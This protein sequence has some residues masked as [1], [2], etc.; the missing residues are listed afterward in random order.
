MK[1]G[2]KL[3][4]KDQKKLIIKDS[5]I[6]EKSLRP[7]LGKFNKLTDDIYW[8]KLPLPF[9][10]D[11]INIFL[12]DSIEGLVIIDCGIKNEVTEKN[13]EK[14]LKNLPLKKYYSGCRY[15]FISSF[16]F[17]ATVFSNERGTVLRD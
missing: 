2:D 15:P 10:L 12:I 8:A 5:L 16:I 4:I 17:N 13:W 14:L 3:I 11:H 6:S 7:E 1:L 9:R